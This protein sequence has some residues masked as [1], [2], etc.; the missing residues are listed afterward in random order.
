MSQC[1][2]HTE[3]VPKHNWCKSNK[4]AS[5]CNLQFYVLVTDGSR[6]AKVLYCTLWNVSFSILTSSCLIQMTLTC[7][8][9]RK[10]HYSLWKQW[11]VYFQMPTNQSKFRTGYMQIIY[12]HTNQLIQI[13]QFMWMELL[14]CCSGISHIPLHH[15]LQAH[16]QCYSLHSW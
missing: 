5:T 4:F 13:N 15:S 11:M 1:F 7:S 2:N 3:H 12:T 6:E 8:F 14:Q 10:I 9:Y 16:R